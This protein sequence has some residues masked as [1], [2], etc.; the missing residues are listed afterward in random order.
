MHAKSCNV[1]PGDMLNYPD[2][3]DALIGCAVEVIQ[4][5]SGCEKDFVRVILEVLV[6]L[7]DK[8]SGDIELLD[9]V[10]AVNGM[11]DSYC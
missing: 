11:F 3:P 9:E 1:F 6:D 10:G 7:R 4:I 5:T 8:D 2:L